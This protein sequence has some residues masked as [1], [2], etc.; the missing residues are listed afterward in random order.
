LSEE[1]RRS[2]SKPAAMNL[3]VVKNFPNRALAEAACLFLKQEGIESVVQSS[4]TVGSGTS[5]GIDLYV[6]EMNRE[7]A[8]RFLERLYDGI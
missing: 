7:K 1:E 2:M 6:Q 4:D 5:Q 8:S 3:V